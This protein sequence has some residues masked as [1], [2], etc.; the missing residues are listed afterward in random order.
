MILRFFVYAGWV[1][2]PSP[3]SWSLQKSAVVVDY[4][5]PPIKTWNGCKRKR[6]DTSRRWY[7][8][9]IFIYIFGIYSRVSTIYFTW[10]CLLS[11]EIENKRA[12]V[13][14]LRELEKKLVAEAQNKRYV[15]M[16]TS[17]F[18]NIFV[19]SNMTH[20]PKLLFKNS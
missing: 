18:N 2:F 17:I 19:L 4:G 16:L 12:E 14:R 5:T 6:K 1:I 15:E 10:V 9:F 7:Y 3:T 11:V 8:S 13:K 20:M